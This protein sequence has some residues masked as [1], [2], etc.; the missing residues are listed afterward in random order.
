MRTLHKAQIK[1]LSSTFSV[2]DTMQTWNNSSLNKYVWKGGVTRADQGCGKKVSKRVS[3][4]TL[5]SNLPN[6]QL[7]MPCP[8]PT[9][10]SGT[11][12]VLFKLY[13]I[14]EF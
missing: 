4:E 12:G 13:L 1:V 11:C 3:V 6:S 2:Q 7:L 5:D 8:D 14:L 10:L 9:A